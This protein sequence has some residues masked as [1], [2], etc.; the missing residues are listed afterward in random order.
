MRKKWSREWISSV[1]PRKQ[2]KYRYNAPLHIRHKLV[3]AHLS[4]ELRERY[5]KRSLPVRKG[6]EVKVMK[7][8]FKGVV[9]TVSRVSLKK[10]KVYID[11]VKVK[12][13]DGTEVMAPIDPSNLMIIKLNLD[14]K[15]RLAVLERAGGTKGE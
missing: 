2:R 9:G 14:D 11:E 13:S 6:D 3:S 7:G 1:Q 5:G 15:K 4:K 12:K 8:K 10:L